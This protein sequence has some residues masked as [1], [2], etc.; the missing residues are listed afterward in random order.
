MGGVTSFIGSVHWWVVAYKSPMALPPL[1]LPP[2]AS[3]L[4][5]A[6]LPSHARAHP[7]E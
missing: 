4:A 2:F 1:S 3:I 5:L 7:L 6:P